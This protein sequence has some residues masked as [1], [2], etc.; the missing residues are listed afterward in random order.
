MFI[1]D[2]FNYI[3]IKRK[4][5]PNDNTT[6]LDILNQ[7]KG[8]SAE[9]NGNTTINCGAGGFIPYGFDG[10]IRGSAKCFYAFIG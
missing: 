2:D 4:L 5:K 3:S 8:C 10:I 1:I 6:F 9:P 7:T